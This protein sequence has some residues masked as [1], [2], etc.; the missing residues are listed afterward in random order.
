MGARIYVNPRVL[1]YV[2]FAVLM[3][4]TVLGYQFFWGLLFL[5]W[6]IPNFYSGHAFLLSD[7]TRDEEPNLFWAVQIAWIV[8]GGSLVVVDLYPLLFEK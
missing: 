6:T 4:S 5:Y 2:T 8:L 7:V 3:I 1:N